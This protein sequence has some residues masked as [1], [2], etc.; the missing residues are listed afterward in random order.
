MGDPAT[1]DRT[2]PGRGSAGPAFALLL[3]VVVAGCFA[4]AN[5]PQSVAGRVEAV[6]GDETPVVV[7]ND[8]WRPVHVYLLREGHQ[9][10][11]LSVPGQS[12]RV[13]GVRWSLLS[14]GR[15]SFLLEVIGS[16]SEYTTVATVVPAGATFHL[17]IQSPLRFSYSYLR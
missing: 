2:A 7:E 11:D 10:A 5:R 14:D 6:P 4:S 15:S 16:G 8:H 9:V 1:L 3:P 17:L 12:T 13:K